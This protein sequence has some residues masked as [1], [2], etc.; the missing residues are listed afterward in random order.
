MSEPDWK[1]YICKAC[2]LI[3]DEREGDP[4]SGLAPG[5]RFEDIPE[6]WKCPLC[7]VK[8]IDFELF[9]RPVVEQNVSTFRA[10]SKEPGIVVIGGGVAAWST[11]TAL[12]ELDPH[13]N[14]TMIT[15]CTGNVYH[16]PELSLAIGRNQNEQ[17]LVRETGIESAQRLAIHLMANTFL[18]SISPRSKTVRTT[19]GSVSY[20]HLILAQGAQN[21][22]PENIPEA[23]SWRVNHLSSWSG[24]QKK[25]SDKTKRVAIVG[26]GMVGCE[27][28]ENLATSGHQ[29]SLI[30]R[31]HTLLNRVIPPLAAKRFEQ[32]LQEQ[33]V[34]CRANNAIKWIKQLNNPSSVTSEI[35]TQPAYELHL[36]SGER[37]VV[38]HIVTA[39]GLSVDQ[40]IPN[41][42][43]IDVN[44]GIVVNPRTLQTSQP[45]IYALGDCI[46]LQGQACRFIAPIQQ[47]ARVIASQIFQENAIEYD[48][49]SPV[50]RLKVQCCSLVLHGQP[51]SDGDW[52][53]VS[54]NEY[55]LRM[56][57]RSG[58][59]LISRLELDKAV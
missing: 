44:Q 45:Q 46:S 38:D 21:Q 5:T 50:I 52:E 56:E 40:R 15:A 10:K 11:V 30:Y 13:T 9:Q 59:E 35:S 41:G 57:Q 24:L 4:D 17:A 54:D 12:R 14:I 51:M 58:N 26:G 3:Y 18:V 55:L 7:G 25:L 47:Q 43:G 48:H 39:T 37:L 27:L 22:L 23:W 28:A 32:Y 6:D 31:S 20:S 16:K 36:D 53:T 33:G 29:V 42:A 2:G 34:D 19:R 49:Q 8:K 1:L